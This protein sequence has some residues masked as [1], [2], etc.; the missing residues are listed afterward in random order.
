MDQR[1]QIS[2]EYILLV[3]IILVIVI[4]FAVVITNQSEQNQVASAA[5]LGAS[6]ATANL[7]FTNGSQTPVKVTSV[8]MTNGS[9]V[10]N[11]VSLTIHFSRSVT[12]QQG[13][14][15]QSIEKSLRANGYNNLTNTN[16]SITLITSTGIGVRHTYFI[17]LTNP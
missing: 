3:A 10:G 2:I 9:T 4:V 8:T 7:I 14:I 13:T 16:S 12:A 5:Q 11:N 15:F 6:N 1:G 17:T